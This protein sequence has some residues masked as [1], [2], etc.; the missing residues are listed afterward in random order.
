MRYDNIS[1]QQTQQRLREL[2]DPLASENSAGA[3]LQRAPTSGKEALLPTW[4]LFVLASWVPPQ[5]VFWSLVLSILMPVEVKQLVGDER[6]TV[7]LGYISTLTSLGSLWGPCLGAW[8]DR[9]VTP[10]GRRRPFMLTGALLFLVSLLVL[11]VATTFSMY[12]AGMFLFTFTAC[13]NCTPYNSILPEIV[14]ESQRARSAS[15]NMW[16]GTI[17]TQVSAALGVAVGQGKLTTYDI[18]YMS[19]AV[20][21]LFALPVGLIIVG[22]RPGCCTPEIPAPPP[23]RGSSAAGPCELARLRVGDFVSAFRYRPFLWMSIIL[24]LQ[25][26]WTNLQSLFY[27]CVALRGASSSTSLAVRFVLLAL[28]WEG[29]HD[30]LSVRVHLS[31]LW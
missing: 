14:P 19:G 24:M 3:G 30:C 2:R 11:R 7:Y 8:S 13:I 1:D 18:Y 23:S 5:S 31:T 6:K 29:V 10:I 16:I 17:F 25:T 15:I 28:L 26:V 4:W 12:A 22:G 9:C 20:S 27:L 21:V